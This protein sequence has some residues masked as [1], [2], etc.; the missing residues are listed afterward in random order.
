MLQHATMTPSDQEHKQG[1]LGDVR[2][3]KL[4]GLKYVFLEFCKRPC[5]RQTM[6]V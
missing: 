5:V 4:E 2:K 3:G 6:N 1:D